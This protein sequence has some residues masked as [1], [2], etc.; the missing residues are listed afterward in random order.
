MGEVLEES[1]G[2]FFPCYFLALTNFLSFVYEVFFALVRRRCMLLGRK[3][4]H[5]HELV[6]RIQYLVLIKYMVVNYV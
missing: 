4:S 6:E 1:F 5:R 3:R 2:V